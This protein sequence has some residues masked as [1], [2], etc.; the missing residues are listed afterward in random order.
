MD[1]DSLLAQAGQAW[2][3]AEAFLAAYPEIAGVGIAVAIG[4][5][6][7]LAIGLLIWAWR[8]IGATLRAAA[9]A[10]IK[11]MNDIGARVIVVRGRPGRQRAI[12]NWLKKSA[13][14]HLKGYMFGGLFKVLNYPGPLE[15]DD[16]AA[17]LLKRSEA[18]LILWAETPRGVKGGV[19][20]IL[21]RPANPFEPQRVPITL[22]MPKEK[23]T[24]GEPLSKAMAY[25]AAKQFRPALGRPQD[26]RAER[27]QPV[28]ESLLVILGYKPK[29]DPKLLAEL[30]D[31]AASG[32]LQLA[33][34][35]DDN[36]LDRSVE[37][38][39]DTLG[40]INRSVSPD[41]WIAAKIN[42]G[43]ALRLRAEKKFD[44]VMLREGIAHLNEALEA[45]RSEPRFKL[46]ESAAQAIGDAQ[47]LLGTRR[48]FSI[49]SGGI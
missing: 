45:L 12:T 35:G 48:K 38:A 43:R 13:D 30:V 23:A 4:F 2:A 41:R 1:L 9:A 18:D 10:R 15:G 31:D 24:W 44:P 39:T 49:S 27:L 17:K 40:E 16:A 37:I 11:R 47:R 29:A 21:S 5:A 20:R 46:A 3:R 36:W 32:A 26:F 14:H 22:A 34:A 6:A 7:A 8:A 42:L 28:V 25:A 33:F 19:A